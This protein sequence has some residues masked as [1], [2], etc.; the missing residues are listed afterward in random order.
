MQTYED[1]RKFSEPSER[2][3][4]IVADHL[5]R[6]EPLSVIRLG[7]AEGSLL[8]ALYDGNVDALRQRLLAQFGHADFA[9][10]DVQALARQIRSAM[11]QADCLGLDFQFGRDDLKKL[12]NAMSHRINPV[13]G[14]ADLARHLD[15][16]PFAAR[17]RLFGHDINRHL[18]RSGGIYRLLDGLDQVTLVTSRSVAP[19][20][21]ALFDLKVDEILV[22]EEQQFALKTL[23]PDPDRIEHYP[24]RFNEV[25]AALR[26]ARQ[27]AV[28]LVGAGFCG[29]VYCNTIKE[30]GGIAIDLGSIFDCWAG[31]VTRPGADPSDTPLLDKTIDPLLRLDAAAIHE[32]TGGEIDRRDRAVPMPGIENRMAMIA[33]DYLEQ[34]DANKVAAINTE[35]WRRV[36]TA[37]DALATTRAENEELWKRVNTAESTLT[38]THEE[39]QELWKRVNGVEATLETTTAENHQL[40]A[41]AFELHKKLAQMEVS[42]RRLSNEVKRLKSEYTVQNLW[43]Y[44]RGAMK[45]KPHEEK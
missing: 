1:F 38:T 6:K 20:L 22:P 42:N 7:A 23:D 8:A 17:P 41:D 21:R 19:A 24:D 33:E 4:K 29:K 16:I 9:F 26:P 14:I 44:T 36:H 18:I 31:L 10:S 15:H 27:G 3:E 25:Q 43:R 11:Q 34:L 2:L 37:E 45:K 28:F 5:Y 30:R 35:L 40:H 12:E 13:A 32:V 39:N